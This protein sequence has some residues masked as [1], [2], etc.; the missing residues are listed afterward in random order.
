M[1]QTLG[2]AKGFMAGFTSGQRSVVIV[3]VLGLLLGAFALSRWVAQPTWAPLYGNL[4]GTDASAVTTQL[5]TDG[6]KYKLADG[7]ATVL[8]PQSQVYSERIALS[9]KGL[10]AG[11]NDDNEGWS[12]LDKQGITATDFQQ[13]IAYQ[14][15]LSG[16]L[17]KTLEAM[18]G[19]NTAIVTLAV[20]QPDVF[21]TATNKT[22]ASVL[23]Q[24]QP[25]VTLTDEQVKA[26]TSGALEL[27]PGQVT[28][29]RSWTR[30]T[31]RSPTRPGRCCPA[32][33]PVRPGPVPPPTR[34]TR[35]PPPTRAG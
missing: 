12:L 13:N 26:L 33:I 35:R 14:R 7:G 11:Q 24:L 1:N 8:V 28:A 31:S 25:G 22:T 10:P 4:S 32:R 9:G 15:A 34:P 17:D 3:A 18:D 6:V 2:K 30:T 23:L 5:T 16:E 20:P 29:W 19:V 27:Y 21:S